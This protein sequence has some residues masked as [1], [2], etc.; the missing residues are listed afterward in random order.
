MKESGIF[1]GNS[2]RENG[3]LISSNNA[4]KTVLHP[5]TAHNQLFHALQSHIGLYLHMTGVLV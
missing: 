1:D 4:T 5:F 3:F 2:A